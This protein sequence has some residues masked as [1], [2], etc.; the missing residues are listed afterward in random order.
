MAISPLNNLLPAHEPEHNELQQIKNC[1]PCGN[2]HSIFC[3]AS[4]WR[5][6]ADRGALKSLYLTSEMQSKLALRGSLGDS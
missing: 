1:N 2:G 6:N 4:L 3:R 5:F